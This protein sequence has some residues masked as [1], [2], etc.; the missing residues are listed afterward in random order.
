MNQLI[1]L[2]MHEESWTPHILN[3]VNVAEMVNY[4]VL[5]QLACLLLHYVTNGFEWRH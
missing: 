1:L 4:R 5:G 2:P 3:V